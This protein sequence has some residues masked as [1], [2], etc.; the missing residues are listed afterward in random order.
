MKAI[1]T[2]DRDDTGSLKLRILS[3]GANDRTLMLLLERQYPMVHRPSGTT[4]PTIEPE[5]LEVPIASS[6]ILEY[7]ASPLSSLSIGSPFEV[8]PANT[9]V[10]RL[11]PWRYALLRDAKLQISRPD[12]WAAISLVINGRKVPDG[13][14][15]DVYPGTRVELTATN[16]SNRPAVLTASLPTAR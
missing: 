12:E 5:F 11:D 10:I 8:E 16:C 9:V 7:P 6:E 15:C 3:E 2:Y 4:D 14:P 1:I 13:A